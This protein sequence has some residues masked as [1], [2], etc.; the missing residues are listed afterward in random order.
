MQIVY[1]IGANCTDGD[2]LLKSLMR[3]G[4]VLAQRR[5]AVPGPGKY[6]KL[7][8]EAVM[9]LNGQPPAP[10]TRDV[11]LDA[12]L[13]GQEADRLI[14]SN[15]TFL[16]QAGRIFEGGQFYPMAEAKLTA[17]RAFFPGDTIE[18]HIG[19]RNPATWLPAVLAQTK[20][21]GL[22]TFMAGMAPEAVA[23]SGLVARIR[24]AAPDMALTVWLNE[25]TPLTWAELLRRI[26]GLA[27]GTPLT[28]E[29]D[30]LAAIMTTDGFARFQAYLKTH[31]PQSEL[32]GRRIAGAFLDKFAIASEIE[33]ELD[34]PGWDARRVDALTRAYE[35]DAEA[36]AAM[37]GLTFVRA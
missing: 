27:D 3:N 17:L 29:H 20:E 14:L 11:L 34:L 33:E 9:N 35:R 1:H 32:Q 22:D 23:W 28:G 2:R 31:A 5:T 30:V 21:R 13:D 37:P 36:V 10:G 18:L 26:T 8:R 16:C 6:R 19:L 25:D 7:L 4:E 15:S 12:I 24:A